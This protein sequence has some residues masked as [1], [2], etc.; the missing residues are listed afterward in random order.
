[1]SESKKKEIYTYVAP[2]PVYGLSVSVREGAKY[3]FRYAMG[4]FIE[5]YCNKV[6]VV[7]LD[8]ETGEFFTR[9]LFD[10]PYPTTKIM[11]RPDAD[12]S[13][14]DLL[15]TTG[16]YLRLWEVV[17][18]G[19]INQVCLLN[20]NKQ[21]EYCAPLTAFDWNQKDLDVVGTASIDTTCTIW[22]INTQK[23]KTQLIAHDKAVYDIAF[24]R[25]KD[26]FAT[27]GADGSVRMFDLRH[28]EH[29]TIMYES[30]KLVPLLR[31]SWN[32]LDTNY[33]ATMLMDSPTTVILDI[34]MPLAPV[35][36]L[37]GHTGCVNSISWA[38]HSSC[39]ICTA[40]DDS[41]ALIWDLSAMPEPIEDPILAYTAGS[42]VNQ[43][44]WG[45]SQP[46]WVSIVFENKMQILRV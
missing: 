16:D 17:D 8:D 42:E 44:V 1:M 4:S 35:A 29:S 23:A 32:Q 10:H 7:Q 19:E 18:G 28:L 34:R 36:E 45:A 11:W 22:D 46:D 37:T 43:L 26:E 21:S 14:K 20:N 24:G 30:P 5:E 15:A 25:H 39:H 13:G 27:V 41:Q 9:G 6:Q 40:G 38:P 2:W 12:A 33:L 3:A 31:L